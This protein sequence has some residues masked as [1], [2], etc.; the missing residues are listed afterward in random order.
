MNIVVTILALVGLCLIALLVLSIA[1]LLLLEIAERIGIALSD[2]N[3]RFIDK[4]ERGK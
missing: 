2:L 1:G 3:Q 4:R